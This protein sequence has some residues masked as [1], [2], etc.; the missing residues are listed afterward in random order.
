MSFARRAT[1]A[2][3]IRDLQFADNA[4]VPVA[5]LLRQRNALAVMHDAFQGECSIARLL[6]AAVQCAATG[7]DAPMAKVLELRRPDNVL[8]VKA[9]V[10]LGESAIG[11]EAGTAEAGNPPGQALITARPVV[12]ADVMKER[13]DSVPDICASVPSSRRSIFRSSPPKARTASSKSITTSRTRSMRPMSP[14][15]RPLRRFS[16]TAS[17][18]GNSARR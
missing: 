4:T 10:G 11:R 15:L 2:A 3:S 16:L 9:Q 13:G 1:W 6:D 5:S 8:I 7:C 14:S 17:N 12:V 18:R